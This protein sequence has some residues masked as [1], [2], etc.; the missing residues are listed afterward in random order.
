MLALG[1]QSTSA[2]LVLAQAAL[3]DAMLASSAT[4]ATPSRHTIASKLQA[5]KLWAGG[6]GTVKVAVAVVFFL[7]L[8][9]LRLFA[10]PSR[11]YHKLLNSG[12]T[13]C[14]HSTSTIVITF[15]LNAF[16]VL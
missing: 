10:P 9:L 13:T 15:T 5:G 14:H 6:G 2:G 3:P 4:A 12:A 7:S 11:L 8:S 1:A 16:I